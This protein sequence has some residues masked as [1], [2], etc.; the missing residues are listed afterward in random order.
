M[1]VVPE[2][3]YLPR[4]GPTDRRLTI[5]PGGPLGPDGPS[6]PG[7]PCVETT[8]NHAWLTTHRGAGRRNA[9]VSCLHVAFSRQTVKKTLRSGEGA[10]PSF[11]SRFFFFFLTRSASLDTLQIFSSLILKAWRAAGASYPCSTRSYG[12]NRSTLS[13]RTLRKKNDG[14][15]SAQRHPLAES[16]T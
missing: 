16:V 4:R 13:R 8:Y 2:L 3:I 15:S 12:A 6:F 7:G 10:V 11:T 14:H 1:N 5:G 9:S